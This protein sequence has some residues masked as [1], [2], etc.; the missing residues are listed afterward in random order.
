MSSALPL[1]QQILLDIFLP[2]IV[3]ITYRLLVFGWT[4]VVQGGRVS[5]ATRRRQWLEFRAILVIMY[6]MA[7]VIFVYAHVIH[8]A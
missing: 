1:P 5:E 7:A 4:Y 6:A 3:A 2:P 8:K